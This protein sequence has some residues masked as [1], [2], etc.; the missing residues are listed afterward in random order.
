MNKK[1]LRTFTA[2]CAAFMLMGGVSVTAF[3][4]VSYTHLDLYAVNHISCMSA[5][6]IN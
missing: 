3:A 1:I 6:G 5:K 4:P 2:L